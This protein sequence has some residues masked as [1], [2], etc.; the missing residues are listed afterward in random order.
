HAAAPARPAAA[1]AGG[2]GAVGFCDT[3]RR[4]PAHRADRRGLPGARPVACG[5]AAAGAATRARG[6]RTAE[7]GVRTVVAL[8]GFRASLPSARR[9]GAPDAAPAHAATGQV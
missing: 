8:N 7:R 6:G 9:G 5:G 3:G 1:A 4:G 2:A